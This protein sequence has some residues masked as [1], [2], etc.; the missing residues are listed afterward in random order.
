[1][2][3]V[4]T[5][6]MFKRAYDG[7]YAIGAFNVNN[8]EVIQGVVEALAMG[9]AP[10]ILQISKGARQYA[11]M[12]YLRKLVEAALEEHKE[13]ELA[14][15]LDHGPDFE[16]CKA[17]VDDPIFTSVMI[18]A[19]A[20]PLEENIRITKQVVDYAH[21]AGKVV[22]AE[23]GRLG[24]IEEHVQVSEKE[25]FLTDPDE[26][27][28]FVER[29]KVDSLAVA[30]GT[31]H[32]A[33]KFKG[34]PVLALDLV[35][36]LTRRLKGFPLVMHGSSSVPQELVELCNK[37]G[38]QLPNARGVPEEMISKAVKMGICKV[39]I[40][41]DIRLA[42]TAKLREFFATQPSVFD[43]R[44]YLAPARD[45]VRNMVLHKLDVLG[46]KGKAVT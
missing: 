10:G 21:A 14:V 6:G 15:H 44:K 5:K 32:G 35:E 45:A 41:T 18:D 13:L 46:C 11:G 30:I 39:N 25:A 38:G 23:L 7:G 20:L 40:D 28:I 26:A 8:M 17:C 43:Y 12:T 16:L 19:S 3:L 29:T 33:Y 34:E 1:M 36:E 42:I 31:S 22:E 4:T 24:G 37:Y 9:N 27:E 2:G